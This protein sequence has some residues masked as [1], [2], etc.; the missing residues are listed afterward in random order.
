MHDAII[1]GAGPNGLVAAIELAR[2]GLDVLVVEA[3]HEPGGG[4]RTAEL[5]RPGFLHD[6]CSGVHP[7]AVA[8]PAL[9]HLPLAEHGLEW[10]HAPLCVAHPL[11]GSPAATLESSLDRTVV[12]M[13][14]DGRAWRNLV[15]PF[16]REWDK[17]A[18]DIL[19]PIRVPRHPLVSARFGIHAL[20][21]ARALARGRFES[22]RVQALFGGLAAH[23][24]LP[25]ERAAT[26]AIG[27][28]LG[29]TAHVGGWP[30]PR[31]GAA[32]L[33][34]ALVRLLAAHG[35]RIQCD[36]R[37]RSLDELPDAR[38]VLLDLTA[39]QV[40]DVAAA[41]LPDSYRRR[42]QQVR[43]GAA[44]FKIDYAL[45]EPIPWKDEACRRAMVV[46]VGGTLDEIIAAEQAVWQRE[47]RA[48]PFVLVSQP[49]LFD[50]SRA[51]SGAHTAWAY[52]HVPTGFTGDAT[53]AVESQLE[54][55]APGFRE[56]VIQRAVLSPAWLERHNPN[57]VGGDIN[58]GAP[59]LRQTLARPTPSWNPYT[60]PVPHLYLCSS[61]TPP[62]G[63]VH[64]MCG[65]NAAHAALRR[66]FGVRN[67]GS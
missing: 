24:M 2:A 48:R 10:V 28:V 14:R 64:G 53:A 55:F 23:G 59:D 60:T 17:L 49:S 21:S 15:A 11:D 58:G 38:A 4:V 47:A 19:R 52:T 36:T 29:I 31:G 41:R 54:R 66:T 37:V 27:L 46:H 44:A 40:A 1:V 51:P 13:G 6:V 65:Y 22:R 9:A 18:D 61:S 5:T 20:R 32:R 50:D 63:G 16:V 25:L 33:S 67:A 7:L 42:L 62:G 56:C 8:A 57:L 39:R 12:A 3:A 30:V 34:D 43:P 35:G 26:A 45:R